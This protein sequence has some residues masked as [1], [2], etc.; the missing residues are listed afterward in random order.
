QRPQPAGPARAHPGQRRVQG[1]RAVPR[2]H[3]RGHEEG[4]GPRRVPRPGEAVLRGAGQ[5]STPRYLALALLVAAVR[6]AAARPTFGEYVKAARAIQEWR[7]EEAQQLSD[8][9]EKAAP[10]EP[11]AQFLVGQVAFLGGSYDDA[12]RRLE[13]LE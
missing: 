4:E 3:P 8:A 12:L 2:G 13:G 6:P 7:Y 11:E 5:V 10:Q 1:L 9:L